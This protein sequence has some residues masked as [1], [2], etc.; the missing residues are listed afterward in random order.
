MFSHQDMDPSSTPDTSPFHRRNDHDSGT[1][2][3]VQLSYF[4]ILSKY[5]RSL[6][7]RH[8][9]IHLVSREVVFRENNKKKIKT[10]N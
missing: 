3:F 8:R 10:V 1:L 6:E 5:A 9:L 2:F 4:G 7:I